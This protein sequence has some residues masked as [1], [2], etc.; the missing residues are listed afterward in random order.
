MKT[1]NKNYEFIFFS[2][3]FL[4]YQ[5]Y[6][7]QPKVKPIKAHPSLRPSVRPFAEL[8]VGNKKLLSL[9]LHTAPPTKIFVLH[10][11]FFLPKKVLFFFW[12]DIKICIDVKKLR[13]LFKNEHV[14]HTCTLWNKTSLHKQYFIIIII[15]SLI[16]C[17]EC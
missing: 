8:L 4:L 3:F 15:I 13:G 9:S 6:L 2:F 17:L 5:L 7:L 14:C 11:F 10:F 12:L 1:E 16:F